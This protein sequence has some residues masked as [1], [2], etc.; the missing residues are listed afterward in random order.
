ML[1]AL[2]K[3]AGVDTAQGIELKR[4]DVRETLWALNGSKKDKKRRAEETTAIDFAQAALKKMKEIQIAYM[5][6]YGR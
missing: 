4:K 2:V 1:C 3:F 5:F 6:N